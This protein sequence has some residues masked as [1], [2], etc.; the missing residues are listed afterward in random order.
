MSNLSFE[1]TLFLANMLPQLDVSRRYRKK[2]E[3]FLSCFPELD[4]GLALV[5]EPNLVQLCQIIQLLQDLKTITD[6]R[7]S[8]LSQPPTYKPDRPPI[9]VLIE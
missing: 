8:T 7:T 9:T 2:P 4:S 5:L 6:I 1:A 3:A